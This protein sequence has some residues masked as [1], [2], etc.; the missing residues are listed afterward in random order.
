MAYIENIRVAV[1]LGVFFVVQSVLPSGLQA[2]GRNYGLAIGSS[3][4]VGDLGGSKSLAPWKTT[5]MRASRLALSGFVEFPTEGRWQIHTGLSFVHLYGDDRFADSPARVARNLHFK[6]AVWEA[7]ARGQ[8][9][10]WDRPRHWNRSSGSRGY[11][12]LG[13]GAF[14]YNPKSRVRSETND[15]N[16][17]VWYSLRELTT[18]GQE[19][20]YGLVALSMPMGIGFDWNLTGGWQV[21]CE[22]NWRYTTTD[23]LDDVSGIYAD[24]SQLSELGAILSSQA[25]AYSVAIA[26]PE[27][28]E[29]VNHQYQVGGVPRGNP[30]SRD[31][32][33]TIQFTL[34]RPDASLRSRPGSWVGQFRRRG[35]FR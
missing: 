6:S 22:I 16:N 28:G 9:K 25:N 10:F 35:F 13:I 20:P 3:H 11:V 19:E 18:E 33:G 7:S 23:Y 21:G 5:S 2:Q 27:G 31:G 14:T 29:V 24:P 26:G 15:I 12:F 32:F 1:V 4:Y 30:E 34:S 17:P 8:F